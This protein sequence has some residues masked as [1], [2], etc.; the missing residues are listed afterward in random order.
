M[1]SAIVGHCRTQV[2]GM[3][4]NIVLLLVPFS[5]IGAPLQD[6]PIRPY[7]LCNELQQAQHACGPKQRCV[8]HYQENAVELECHNPAEAAL[9][10]QSRL[11][12]DVLH[13]LTLNGVFEKR[14]QAD[15]PTPAPIVDSPRALLNFRRNRARDA[16]KCQTGVLHQVGET[17]K[18]RKVCQSDFVLLAAVNTTSS[19]G[20]GVTIQTVFRISRVAVSV[21]PDH[22]TQLSIQGNINLNHRTA[23]RACQCNIL[24]S[25]RQY[26]FMGQD[27]GVL[28]NLIID[29]SS[30]IYPWTGAIAT[31]I[32]HSARRCFKLRWLEKQYNATRDG[33]A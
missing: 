33:T 29:A 19:V 22:L 13:T 27:D 21:L 8:A 15:R 5:V 16:C 9:K 7:K 4:L 26:L 24:E 1:M 2:A 20:F 31:H 30:A 11:H 25:G 32:Q 6:T 3:I 14:K 28:G 23:S 12:G 10:I 17:P 18:L